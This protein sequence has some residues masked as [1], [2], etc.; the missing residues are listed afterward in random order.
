MKGDKMTDST[1]LQILSQMAVQAELVRESEQAKLELD[2]QADLLALAAQLPER[3][4][5]F[6]RLQAEVTRRDIEARQA[7]EAEI[8]ATAER[9]RA[10]LETAAGETVTWRADLLT[11]S[12][13][14]KD[15]VAGSNATRE[16][17][18]RLNSHIASLA[19]IHAPVLEVMGDLR[20]LAGAD[21]RRLWSDAGGDDERFDLKFKLGEFEHRKHTMQTLKKLSVYRLTS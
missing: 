12:A 17:Y 1:T 3:R 2:R 9:A 14:S 15:V 21:F 18:S 16:F 11:I 10:I 8:K 7:R 4:A 19:V 20:A 6:D 13:T 5:E